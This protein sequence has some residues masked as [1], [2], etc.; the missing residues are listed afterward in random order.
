MPRVKIYRICNKC[1]AL[2]TSQKS[3]RKRMGY[4][5]GGSI[6]YHRY[7]ITDV[8]MVRSDQICDFIS[9][10]THLAHAIIVIVTNCLLPSSLLC[11]LDGKVTVLR[12]LCALDK[13]RGFKIHLKTLHQQLIMRLFRIF[14]SANSRFHYQY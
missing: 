13:N 10:L 4:S 2:K 3:K 6:H 5:C 7:F 11:F 14:L 1:N 9:C 12:Y 8:G